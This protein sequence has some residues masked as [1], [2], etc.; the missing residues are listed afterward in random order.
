MEEKLSCLQDG[1][2]G[3]NCKK[4]FITLTDLCPLVDSGTDWESAAITD[5]LMGKARSKGV[6]SDFY[7]GLLHCR[8]VPSHLRHCPFWRVR[9]CCTLSDMGMLYLSPSHLQVK[10]NKCFH[11][12][13][14]KTG[15][16]WGL[17]GGSSFPS[18]SM[19][20]P[21]ADVSST[22]QT[23]H[24]GARGSCPQLIHVGYTCVRILQE[25]KGRKKKPYPLQIPDLADFSVD[26]KW[27][28]WLHAEKN[29]VTYSLS[30]FIYRF[31]PSF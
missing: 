23:G 25:L 30:R 28:L 11:N 14:G 1:I 10:A 5:N 17:A 27:T 20:K 12:R 19:L 7:L 21:P 13:K 8:C 3:Q 4:L 22:R 29:G 2:Y 9:V 24:K 15:N 31:F 16:S 26:K 18:V 6:E